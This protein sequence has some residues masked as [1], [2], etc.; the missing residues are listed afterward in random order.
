MNDAK[1]IKTQED[2]L[3]NLNLVHTIEYGPEKTSIWLIGANVYTCAFAGTVNECEAYMRG[4][5]HELTTIQAKT[6]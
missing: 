6:E 3:I 2:K 1:W 5:E 4:L